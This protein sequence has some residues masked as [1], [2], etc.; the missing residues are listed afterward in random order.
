MAKEQIKKVSKE[1]LT[2]IAKL[3]N[4][5]DS[6]V[7]TYNSLET[8]DVH[9]LENLKKDFISELSNLASE[10]GYFKSEYDVLEQQRKVAKAVAFEKLIDE[11][12]NATK[13]NNT[14]YNHST[15]IVFL[16][17]YNEI[18]RIYS[19]IRVKYD[20][21]NSVFSSILQSISVGKKEQDLIGN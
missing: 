9:S 13:A 5:L 15:Y 3:I 2:N 1:R 12:N 10:Y 8:T 7:D 18:N 20:I 21:F 11:G 19:R 6:Y 4:G 16:E 17:R 14:V